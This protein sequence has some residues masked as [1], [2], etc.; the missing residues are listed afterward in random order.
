M[1]KIE[2]NFR[3]NLFWNT[4]TISFN[5]DLEKQEKGLINIYPDTQFQEILGF[6]GA[7]TEAS[8]YCFDRIN[9][10][11]QNQIL[12]EYFSHKGLQYSFCRLPI[13]SCDFAL[14]SYSYLEKE[15]IHTFSIDRDEKFI[16]PLIK[17]A[18]RKN[19]SLKL[20]ASPWSPP[21]FMKDNQSLILGGKLLKEYYDLYAQYLT[22]YVLEYQKREILIDFITIQ[23][24]P[25]AIQKWESCLFSPQEEADFAENYLHPK[26]MQSQIQTKIL[27]WDHNKERLFSRANEIY[28]TASKSISGMAMHWYSGDYFEEIALTAK[29][30]PDKLLIHTEGCTGFSHF[31]KQD[32]VQNAEIYAHDILGDLNAGINGFIDWNILLDHKGG[33]NHKRNYCNAPIMLN[34]NNTGYIKNLTYYYIGHFSKYIKP[35]AKKIGF[36]R[37][38]SD[39]EVTAFKNVD[40]SLIVILL[41]RNNFNKEFTL[42]INGKTFHD[43]L[44]AHAILTFII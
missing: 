11:M 38:T 28:K 14:S 39:I 25:N 36:S 32:E 3:R 19:P 44:D 35:G 9:P 31:R 37:F 13:G 4:T 7:L 29:A 41:N 21:A 43:N 12:E 40:N 6:G 1:L 26:F 8:G 2:T 20:L 17:N 15:D 23:N 10:L 33:P 5:K 42:H 22:K 30:Y 16:I 34:A 24:E 18:L 27:S